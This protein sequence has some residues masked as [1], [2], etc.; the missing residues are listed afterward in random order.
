MANKDFDHATTLFFF[1]H[2]VAHIN[3]L[4]DF[5]FIQSPFRWRLWFHWMGWFMHI[6]FYSLLK[7]VSQIG[8][9]CAEIR[10]AKCE[11]VLLLRES[12][13]TNLL[14]NS[15]INL[16]K[17]LRHLDWQWA[18]HRIRGWQSEIMTIVAKRKYAI[19]IS[20]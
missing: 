2:T 9:R 10:L 18:E 12:H 4:D 3:L 16:V 19:L 13:N 14:F 7:F 8:E 6:W 11:I 15:W 17:E 1:L 20:S 5:Y